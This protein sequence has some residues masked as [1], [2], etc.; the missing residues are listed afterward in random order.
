MNAEEGASIR[1]LR[2]VYAEEA[3]LS[4]DEAPE[5]K[6]LYAIGRGE[7]AGDR[8]AALEAFRRL[9]EVVGDALGTV[10][11]LLDGLAVVGGG[12]SGAASLFLPA[13][14]D[15]LN[16]TYMDPQGQSFR[17]LIPR[18]FNLEDA[19]H[20]QPFLQGDE[21]RITIPGSSRQLAYD[22]LPRLGVGLSVLGTSQ[23]VARG[24][25][26]FALRAL[27]Q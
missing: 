3:G 2:R 13:L 16:S 23:A 21:R 7:A 14:V 10:M 11:T 4:F 18:A 20:L 8:A 12:L 22:P 6:E 19:E 15:E 27:E 1:A 17:R 9:G 24:A 26:A 5:P 25:Y